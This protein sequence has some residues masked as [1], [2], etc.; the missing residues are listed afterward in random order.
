MPAHLHTTDMLMVL[1]RLVLALGR[2][3]SSC[4]GAVLDIGCEVAMRY[5]QIPV[6]P[7]VTEALCKHVSMR[8]CTAS[9]R[10]GMSTNCWHDA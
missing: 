10:S 1:L 4:Q 6:R 2:V 5:L 3:L 9:H 7:V 8:L